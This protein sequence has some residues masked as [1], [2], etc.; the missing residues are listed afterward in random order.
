MYTEVSCGISAGGCLSL[1]K[2]GFVYQIIL[3]AWQYLSNDNAIQVDELS[4][5]EN[6]TGF[7][8]LILTQVAM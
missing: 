3:L 7:V 4:Q 1:K 5:Y 6:H 2:I 8:K